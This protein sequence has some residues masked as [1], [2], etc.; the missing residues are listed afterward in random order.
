MMSVFASESFDLSS[1]P[2]LCLSDKCKLPSCSGVYFALS[3]KGRV[4]YIGRSV[5][6]LERLKK[7][8][9]LP[10]L[11]ALGGVKIAWL[12]QSNS[13]TLPRLEQTLIKCFNPPLNKIPLDL[14][15]ERSEK[16]IKDLN[17]TD[18]INKNNVISIKKIN[19]PQ[20][21]K[22][23]LVD[24]IQ[25]EET[26]TS[27]FRHREWSLSEFKEVILEQ[28][29]NIDNLEKRM[30]DLRMMVQDQTQVYRELTEVLAE[31]SRIICELSR[32]QAETNSQLSKVAVEQALTISR[33]SDAIE[34]T[35][36]DNKPDY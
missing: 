20:L 16:I 28:T 8:H 3:S 36:Y 7:H 5:N 1:L 24:Q 10:L 31:Q 14:N 9:R 11:E 23:E 21:I 33:L 6:I 19:L 27:H 18:N 13:F 4:L 22:N 34:E 15:K 2:C 12:E 26:L 29:K 30:A 35:S 32:T 17:L 25:A